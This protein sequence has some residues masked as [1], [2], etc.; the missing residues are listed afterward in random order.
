MAIYFVLVCFH[1]LFVGTCLLMCV[2]QYSQVER[3]AIGTYQYTR[4]DNAMD[5]PQFCRHFYRQGIIFAFNES[6]IFN[7]AIDHG[8][9]SHSFMAL[10]CVNMYRS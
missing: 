4:Q 1:F 8:I 10:Y 7:P 9:P 6:F 5:P 2:E 3:I